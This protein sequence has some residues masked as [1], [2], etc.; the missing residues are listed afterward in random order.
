L[1]GQAV[2]GGLLVVLGS[3]GF[4]GW[5]GWDWRDAR[6]QRER[7]AAVEDARREEAALRGRMEESHA[8]TIEELARLRIDRA[9]ADAAG[10]D[11]RVRLAGAVAAARAASAAGSAPA[12]G[13]GD[14]IGVL[15][16]V[17]ERADAAAEDLAAYA[18]STRAAGLACERSY[19]ALKRR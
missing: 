4:G 10:R 19:E 1:T 16:G 11:L 17:L 15:A 7:V 8:R 9:A 2:L 12:A 18:D 5:L 14:P 3:A 6:A 13:G